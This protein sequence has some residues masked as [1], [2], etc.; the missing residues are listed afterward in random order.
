MEHTWMGTKEPTY[1]GARFL[2]AS[3]WH[4]PV[5]AED[6]GQPHLHHITC[7]LFHR[8]YC[9]APHPPGASS[10]PDRHSKARYMPGAP[11]SLALVHLEQVTVPPPKPGM[12]WLC[13]QA[14]LK[15]RLN[16]F[17]IHGVGVGVC[18]G[19]WFSNQPVVESSL[20]CTP[21]SDVPTPVTWGWWRCGQYLST[22]E[23]H[24]PS[25]SE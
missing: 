20:A 24:P 2:R 9:G 22:V 1:S 5:P 23:A 25:Q 12:P 7:G 19:V 11:P 17:V 14:D 4:F 21:V 13:P 15:Q 18:G 8:S 6:P 16:A 10:Q 3:T